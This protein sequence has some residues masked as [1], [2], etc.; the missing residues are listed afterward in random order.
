ME[1]VSVLLLRVLGM[2]CGIDIIT[3]L[4]Y[5]VEK[6]ISRHLLLIISYFAHTQA[7]GNAHQAKPTYSSPANP[8]P[9]ILSPKT[10]ALLKSHTEY[11]L[12]HLWLHVLSSPSH[13]SITNVALLPFVIF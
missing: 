11:L 13:N 1:R 4:F 6:D 12:Q 5:F 7:L 8:A 9:I 2:G 3:M 10:S